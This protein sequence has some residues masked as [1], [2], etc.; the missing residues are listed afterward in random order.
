MTDVIG[1][2][3]LGQIGA[4]IAGHLVAWPGGLV[5][6]DLRVEATAPLIARGAAVAAT[7]AELAR[8][9]DVIEVMVL[10]DGQVREVVAPMITAARPGTVIAIHSTIRP[11][12][13]VELAHAAAEC[14][15]HVVDA[16]VSGGVLGATSGRLAV[17]VGGAPD[18]FE[19]CRQPFGLWAE[20]VLHVGPA[21]AGTRAKL[22][23]NLIQLISFVA[24]GEGE[25]LAAAAGV[26]LRQLALITRHSDGITGGPS[27]IMVRGV[28]GPLA[29]DDP[30]YG[31]FSHTRDLG[32]KD[33]ALALELAA[34]VG[35]DL[36]LTRLALDRFAEAL[37][38]GDRV[39]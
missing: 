10:D 6:C 8:R 11:A 31:I 9:A 16:P 22:A 32:E 5:V 38:V 25:R 28:T 39:S 35:V 3:G 37:G 21:G 29:L 18:A 17:M 30:L 15:V 36:P 24:A 1:F 34:D 33:L 7:P 14:G 23:R 19:R 2:V 27:A 12:T 13:A 20:V 26:D 4:P